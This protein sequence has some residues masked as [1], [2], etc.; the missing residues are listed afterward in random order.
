LDMRIW[1]DILSPKQ[2]FLF[3]SLAKTL[4]EL[5]HEPIMTS[6]HYIQLDDLLDKFSTDW[7]IARIGSWGGGSLEGKLRASIDRLG[8]LLDHIIKLR[9]DITFSSGSVEASRIS[10]GLGI[11]HILISDTPHSPVNRL[12]APLS[13]KVFTPWIIPDDEW[14]EAGA[15]PKSIRHYRALDP[16]FWLKDFKPSREQLR[17]LGLE[18]GEYVLLRMP[19]TMA[20]YLRMSDEQLLNFVKSLAKILDGLR[21]VIL[22]RYREQSRITHRSLKDERVLVID[23]PIFGQ[24]LIYYSSIFIGGGG[25]MTQE[26]ALLG[27]P[28]ISIYPR[29]LPTVIRFLVEKGLILYYRDLERLLRDFGKILKERDSLREEC[30]VKAENLWKIMEDPK[31]R[32]IGE[33]FT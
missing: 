11:P 16:C 3:T 8:R 28:A 18:E 23:K 6:R 30:K 27:V 9:P 17:E 20:S 15:H 4:K 5:G 32:V 25:T 22:C 14:I 2:L 13:E 26:A 7:D 10:Y 21:L 31:K 24:S 1:L 19:E 33:V 29:K 12:V